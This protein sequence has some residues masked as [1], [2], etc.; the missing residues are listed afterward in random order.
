M[1]W[2]FFERDLYRGERGRG[3]DTEIRFEGAE[4]SINGISDEGSFESFESD[5]SFVFNL[6][7]GVVWNILRKMS[8]R[9]YFFLYDEKAFKILSSYR[10]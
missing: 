7:T 5:V 6:N 2:E 4:L 10:F 9:Y 3:G 8:I 1:I